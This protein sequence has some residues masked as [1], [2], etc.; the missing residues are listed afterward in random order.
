M[1]ALANIMVLMIEKAWVVAVAALALL[2]IVIA[3]VYWRT[4]K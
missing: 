2:L 1:E 3:I 4:G